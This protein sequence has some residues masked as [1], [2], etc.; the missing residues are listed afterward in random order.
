MQSGKYELLLRPHAGDNERTPQGQIALGT[1][2]LDV[3]N[4]HWNPVTVRLDQN[5]V[6]QH[7]QQLDQSFAQAQAARA[8]DASSGRNRR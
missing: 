3:E 5:A 1:F 2:E 7:L 4:G 8:A 6:L